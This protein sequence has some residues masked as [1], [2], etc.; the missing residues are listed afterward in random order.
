MYFIV[1]R[2]ESVPTSKI[3]RSDSVALKAAYNFV[4]RE[5]KKSKNADFIFH[6]E[7]LSSIG[8]TVIQEI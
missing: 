1:V 7:D 3:G 6:W 2:G 5:F 8:G 4:P